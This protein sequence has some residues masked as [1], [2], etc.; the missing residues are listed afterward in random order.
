MSYFIIKCGGSVLD[1]MHPS[2]FENIVLMLKGHHIKPVIVHGGGPEISSMLSKLNI[3][4]QFVEG[5]RV[6]TNHV[7]D[8]VEMTL[9]GS[10][11]KSIVRKIMECG[12]CAIGIS[13]V[14]GMLLQAK[15]IEQGSELGYVGK[16]H[17]VN[18]K[19][20]ESLVEES[21]IPVIS[22]VG[23]D[24]DSQRWNVNADLAAA[25][26]AKALHAPLCLVTNVPGIMKD[27]SVLPKLTQLDIDRL[28][29]DQII[30]GGMIPKVKAVK[31]C[32]QEGISEVVI[33]NGTEENAL[34]RLMNGE[35]I[36][37]S[38]SLEPSF[39]K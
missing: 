11:N 10:M 22:P 15:P 27:G 14:D 31:E 32:L 20:I 39:S 29:D 19:I 28:L 8:V 30:T 21:F 24:E 17:A 18:E 33:L 7:L 4:S 16:V 3:E 2:F 1:Q 13:G 12:G 5:M 25:A 35:E 34:I 37:T 38:I 6:T 36:G 23:I 9:S 26:I